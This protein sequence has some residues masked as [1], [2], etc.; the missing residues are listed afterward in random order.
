MDVREGLCSSLH[1][2]SAPL[3]CSLEQTPT[4]TDSN[5]VFPTADGIYEASPFTPQQTPGI[6]LGLLLPYSTPDVLP[7]SHFAQAS[8]VDAAANIFSA[9]TAPTI[10]KYGPCL[11]SGI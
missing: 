8:A 9:T 6:P 4:L 2:T 3:L 10:R 5:R 11:T 7:S 1:A